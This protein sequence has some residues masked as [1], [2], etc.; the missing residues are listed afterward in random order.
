M[1]PSASVRV[2]VRRSEA[3]PLRD[4]KSVGWIISSFA[5]ERKRGDVDSGVEGAVLS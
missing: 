3:D 2:A 5:D 1:F 4:V